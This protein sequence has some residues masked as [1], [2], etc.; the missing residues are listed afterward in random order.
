M[1]LFNSK[2]EQNIIN[3]PDNK[4][5]G[6][7]KDSRP[8]RSMT[9]QTGLKFEGCGRNLPISNTT[10]API[11]IHNVLSLILITVNFKPKIQQILNA[12]D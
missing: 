5:S 4:N 3:K 9:A 11:A 10:I 8:Q 6:R 12:M 1:Y 7:L 2:S